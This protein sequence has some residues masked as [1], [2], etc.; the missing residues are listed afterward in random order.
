HKMAFN[1]PVFEDN[2]T[3]PTRQNARNA[4]KEATVQDK[5]KVNK[6]PE[7]ADIYEEIPADR[8]SKYQTLKSIGPEHGYATLGN[9][10]EANRLSYQTVGRLSNVEHTYATLGNGSERTFG[11]N[12]VGYDDPP[13]YDTIKANYIDVKPQ[14]GSFVKSLAC[15]V[16][17]VVLLCVAVLIGGVIIGLFISGKLDGK[18]H[19]DVY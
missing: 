13:P 12:A 6:E 11:D 16:L 17:I 2:Y 19:F 8:D 14:K 4:S 18:I 7:S 3:R 15:K 5:Y 9:N 1:N 10:L